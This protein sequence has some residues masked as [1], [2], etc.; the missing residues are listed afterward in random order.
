[1]PDVYIAQGHGRRPDGTFDPGASDGVHNEQRD[2]KPV[3]DACTRVLREAGIEVFSEAEEHDD[4]NYRGTTSRANDMG[5]D[6]VVSF[7]F[8]WNQAPPGA[9]MIATTD[10]GRE[11][12][13]AIENRV[14]EAGFA[15]RDYRDDRDGLYLLDHSNAPAV[16]FECGRIGHEDI[17]ETHEQRAM[18]EAA[19]RGILNWLGL[20]DDMP[21]S[22]SDVD[23]V[24]TAVVSRVLTDSA[25]YADPP[26]LGR[27]VQLIRATV[28]SIARAV[29]SLD[30]VD[31]AQLAR[32]IAAELETEGIPKA[33]ADL[34]AARLA[35]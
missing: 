25:D 1:M 5:V 15:I 34:I 27:Q 12:G 20:E 13:W 21:L 11:L 35:G 17:D 32:D 28:N 10:E 18:G 23:R 16:I 29:N 14:A 8:D 30:T 33:T 19:A 31:S 2:S 9:F 6:A 26:G 24:A 4:P 3:A 22:N 7:H